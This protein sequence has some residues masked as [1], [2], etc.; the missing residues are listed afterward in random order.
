MP[1]PL[2]IVESPAKARTIAGFLGG[3]YTVL[4]SVGHI[5]DLV[6]KGL[7]VD[8]D[9]D[10]KPT[11][12]VYGNKKDV[13]RDL[14]SALKD[15]SELYLATDEDR[16][17]EAI[18]WHLLEELKPKVPVKRMVFHEITPQAIERAVENS[19]R[20]RLRPGRRPG[21]PAH[22]STA[23]TATRCRPCCGARSTPGCRPAGCRASPSA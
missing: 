19:A 15:A 12:E 3:E 23:S 22:R 6:A 9:N 4:S 11:Y 16:E 5:R 10:F 2:V 8:V 13:I 7:S 20:H 18:S 1:K 17:G 14:R 21:D